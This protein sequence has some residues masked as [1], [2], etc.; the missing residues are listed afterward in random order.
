MIESITNIDSILSQ[1]VYCTHKGRGCRKTLLL[2]ELEVGATNLKKKHRSMN[3]LDQFCFF[4]FH[5][6]S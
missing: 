4:L 3:N 6:K 5:I 2:S 1:E